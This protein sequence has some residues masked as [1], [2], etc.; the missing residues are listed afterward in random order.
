MSTVDFNEWFHTYD[1]ELESNEPEDTEERH[2]YWMFQA[3]K[4]GRIQAIEETQ[5]IC[6]VVQDQVVENARRAL[7][8]RS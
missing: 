8:S 6:R 1:A 7:P 3:Y 4:A 2:E 5:A